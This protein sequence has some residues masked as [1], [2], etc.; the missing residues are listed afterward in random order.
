MFF[1]HRYNKK[2]Q[3]IWKNTYLQYTM[4]SLQLTSDAGQSG[5]PAFKQ[6]AQKYG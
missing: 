3:N 4:L 2:T 5:I 6:E 1:C